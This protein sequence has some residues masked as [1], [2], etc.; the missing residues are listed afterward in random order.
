MR[1]LHVGASP[2]GER[3]ISR[4]LTKEFVV[5]WRAAF[6]TVRLLCMALMHSLQVLAVAFQRS[7]SQSML[8]DCC[9]R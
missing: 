4:Q 3:S 2:R 1:I 6:P 5:A 9:P 8:Q 7:H